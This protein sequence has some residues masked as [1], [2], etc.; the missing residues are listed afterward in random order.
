MFIES[1]RKQIRSKKNLEIESS[2]G[3]N[4]TN[5]LSYSKLSP[6][7]FHRSPCHLHDSWKILAKNVGDRVEQIFDSFVMGHKFS[8]PSQ[9]RNKHLN[10][11]QAHSSKRAA[12]RVF[13]FYSRISGRYGLVFYVQTGITSLS[14]S[15]S[16]SLFDS[17]NFVPHNGSHDLDDRL[18]N[19]KNFFSY[20]FPVILLELFIFFFQNRMEFY[21]YCNVKLIVCRSL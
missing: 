14:L 12:R 10:M 18:V 19:L 16:L 3:K 2:S 9:K 13:I 20:S 7:V 15:L 1:N 8:W 4:C 6:I 21:I 5:T 11:H 17:V